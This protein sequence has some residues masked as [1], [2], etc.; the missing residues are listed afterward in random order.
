MSEPAQTL[1][2][3]YTLHDFRTMDWSSWKRLSSDERQSALDEFSQYLEKLNVVQEKK[4]A[5]MPF[6][7]LLVK[8]QI[9]C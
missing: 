9:S 8:R 3:W 1:D 5:V 4:K 2:G 7:P 6:I